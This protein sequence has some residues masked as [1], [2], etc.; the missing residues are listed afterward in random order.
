MLRDCVELN[1]V[2]RTLT[3]PN[4]AD[5][6]LETLHNWPNYVDELVARARRWAKVTD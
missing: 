3:W 2:A 4:W 5:F 1:P 6:D